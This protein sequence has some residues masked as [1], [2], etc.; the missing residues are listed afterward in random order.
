MD[1]RQ[2]MMI[3][4]AWESRG[5]QTINDDYNGVSDWGIRPTIIQEVVMIQRFRDA[6]YRVESWIPTTTSAALY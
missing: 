1:F 3:I 4:M 6:V 5:F 2:L